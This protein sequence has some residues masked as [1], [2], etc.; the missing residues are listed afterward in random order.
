MNPDTTQNPAPTPAQEPTPTPAPAPESVAALP[1]KHNTLMAVLAYIGPLVLVSYLTA[2]DDSFVKFHIKQGLVLLV[3]EVIVW[4]IVRMIWMLWPVGQIVHLVVFILA[5]VGIV[6][7]L[8][9][10]EK[11]LPFVGSFAAHFK[12]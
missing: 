1:P 5:I 12:I 11:A 2:K 10:R 7:V 8:K 9:G 4:V 6:N 3:I